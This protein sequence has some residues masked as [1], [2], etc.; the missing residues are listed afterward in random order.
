MKLL[1]VTSTVYSLMRR[2]GKLEGSLSPAGMVGDKKRRA[3]RH[4]RA[5]ALVKNQ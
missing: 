2:T 5:L 3:L 1:P 4:N